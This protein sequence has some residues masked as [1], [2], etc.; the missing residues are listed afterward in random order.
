MDM[1]LNDGTQRSCSLTKVLYVPELAYNLVSVARATEAGK[2]VQFDDSSCEFHN[3]SGETIALGK[4]HWSLYYLEFAGKPQE[5]VS[6]ARNSKVNKER[7][8]HRRFGHLNEQ[9]MQK[10][11]RKQLVNRFDYDAWSL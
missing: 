7:L 2:D 1:L 5:S 4:R 8:W 3:E 6:V 11:V 9:S 10:L